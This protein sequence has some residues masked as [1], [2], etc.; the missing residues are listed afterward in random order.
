MLAKRD[1]DRASRLKLP[2]LAK[3]FASGLLMSHQKEA[4]VT[5]SH[6]T[7]GSVLKTLRNH[8]PA[9]LA[10]PYTHPFYTSASGQ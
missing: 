5:A 3:V 2:P 8:L 6:S 10:T 7:D 9:R 4:L 1:Y